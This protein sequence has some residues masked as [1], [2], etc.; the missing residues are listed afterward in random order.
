MKSGWAQHSRLQ[1]GECLAEAGAAG[2]DRKLVVDQPAAAVGQDGRTTGEACSVLL[3]SRVINSPAVA[4]DGIED[5]V[6]G[7]V[8][9][10][11]LWVRVVLIEIASDS[12][13][14]FACGL[15]AIA[16]SFLVREGRGPPFD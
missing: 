4:S 8:P 10:K 12:G 11:R 7:F 13:F 15:K 3:V 6:G 14:Q 16:A 2:R 5:L 1:L 9:D